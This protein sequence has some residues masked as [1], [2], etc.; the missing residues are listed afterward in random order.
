M[1]DFTVMLSV[2]IVVLT[3]AFLGYAGWFAYRHIV[4]A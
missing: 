3:C 2:L 4:S 1:F